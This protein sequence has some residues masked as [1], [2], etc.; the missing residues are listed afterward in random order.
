[1]RGSSS[2][3]AYEFIYPIIAGYIEKHGDVDFEVV[4]IEPTDGKNAR[5]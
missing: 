5:K 1:M 4:D 2:R 3:V